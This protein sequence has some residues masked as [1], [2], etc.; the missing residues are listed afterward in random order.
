[1]AVVNPDHLLDQAEQLF[2]LLHPGGA[3]RQADRRRAISSAY[4]AV[5]HFVLTEGADLFV[6]AERRKLPRYALVYRGVDHSALRRLCEEVI[7][8]QPSTKYRKYFP[9]GGFGPDMQAFAGAVLELREKREIADYDPSQWIKATDATGAIATAR[10]AISLFK[11]A[12]P[13]GQR[14]RVFLTLLFFPPR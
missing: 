8:P 3:L 9:E 13:E 12:S 1:M 14:R 6:G 11:A 4:Y 10:S 5:F 7:K 2:Q